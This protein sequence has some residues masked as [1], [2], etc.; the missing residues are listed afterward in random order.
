MITVEEMPNRRLDEVV[1]LRRGHDLTWRD[2]RPGNVPVMGSAGANGTHNR[3]LVPGPGVVL[4][5]SGAAYGQAHYVD[6]DYWPHNTALY[7]TDFHGNNPRFVFHLLDFIDFSS[8]NSGGAQQ[9]LNR[10]FIAGIVLGVPDADEQQ[11]IANAIDDADRL[12]STLQRIIAKKTAIKHGMLQQLL[13]GR[14]RL[15]GFHAPWVERAISGL[16][17]VAK[18]VQL[19]RAAMETGAAVPVWNGGVEPSGFTKVPNVTRAVVTVSEGG[20]SCGWVGRPPGP[21]WLGG[22]CYAL[23]TKPDGHSVTFLYHRLKAAEREIMALRVG[24]GLPN[25]QKKRLADFVLSVPTDSQEAAALAAVLDDADLELDALQ[26]RLAKARAIKT[27]IMQQLLTG[28]TRL[29]REAAS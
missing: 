27:G 20:N 19:G 17:F 7:V 22:H 16:A 1:S 9:S 14:T 15:P 18:G 25:I 6:V 13:T 3:A 10:N 5:R 29:L 4:G 11:R 24:S 23:D 2:R 8:H 26:A 12:I 28:R 21:F